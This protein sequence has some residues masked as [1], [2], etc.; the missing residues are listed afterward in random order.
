MAIKDF[1]S[2]NGYMK[3]FLNRC[4]FIY[5]PADKIAATLF[6]NWRKPMHDPLPTGTRVRILGVYPH[7][8]YYDVRNLLE[9]ATGTTDLVCEDT[10]DPI[11]H[12]GRIILDKPIPISATECRDAQQEKEPYFFRVGIE[13][14][15]DED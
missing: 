14:L 2:P 5:E 6:D 15:K 3:D 9:G 10:S 13:I 7:D 4:S 8:A 11:W 1:I 12:Y